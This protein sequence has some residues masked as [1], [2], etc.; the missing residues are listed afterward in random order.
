VRPASKRRNIRLCR[1]AVP[2]LT[3]MLWLMP[4]LS[5]FA[6]DNSDI[7]TI[8]PDRFTHH[9]WAQVQPDYGYLNGCQTGIRAFS[10]DSTGR[11]VF[12]K[13]IQGSWWV[14]PNG[15]GLRT[16]DGKRLR[17]NYDLKSTLTPET[18]KNRPT[19]LA[20]DFAVG[21]FIFHRFDQFQECT[22]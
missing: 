5:S 20:T 18:P 13:K 3:A 22:E 21:T 4:A 19:N 11:F 7:Q 16:K 2:M 6:E 8:E 10:F 14:E 9:Y 15:I 1:I 17:L 12:N